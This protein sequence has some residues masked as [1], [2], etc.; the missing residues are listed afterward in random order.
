MCLAKSQS[1]SEAR[2]NK[3]FMISY[4]PTTLEGLSEGSWGLFSHIYLMWLN[5]LLVG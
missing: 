5:L 3:S 1:H 2:G 4:H